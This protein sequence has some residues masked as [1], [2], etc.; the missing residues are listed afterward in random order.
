MS[1]APAENQVFEFQRE[2]GLSRVGGSGVPEAEDGVDGFGMMG[3]R[4]V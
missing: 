1:Q 2:S 4:S 3:H